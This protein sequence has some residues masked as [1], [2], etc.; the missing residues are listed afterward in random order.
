MT[1]AEKI[2]QLFANEHSYETW[3]EL[4]YDSHGQIQIEYTLEVM[5]QIAQV[6]FDA[7]SNREDYLRLKDGWTNEQPDKETFINNLF[8]KQTHIC[9]KTTGCQ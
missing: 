5:K 3:D 1:Q 4:M 9:Q 2:L 8:N 7:G 6:S